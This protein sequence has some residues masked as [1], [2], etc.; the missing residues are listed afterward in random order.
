MV[1]FCDKL[2]AQDFASPIVLGEKCLLNQFDE[3]LSAQASS[4]SPNDDYLSACNNADSLPMPEEDFDSCLI[5]W[6]KLKGEKSIYAKVGKVAA[7]ELQI[8][9]ET[10][11]DAP[12]VEM[13][14]FWNR[15]EDWMEQERIIAPSGVNNMFQT[16]FAFWWY[17][18]NTTLLRTAIGAAGIAVGFSAIVVLF[19]SRS[20]VL[21]LFSGFCIVYVLSATTA[22]LVGFGWKLGL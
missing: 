22:S 9:M 2:F 1:G 7:I 18:T 4:D 10:P 8:A 13:D 16:S 14:E 19:S 21:T 11:W 20:F 5:S 15:I 12:Y 6:S 17:D 3:W